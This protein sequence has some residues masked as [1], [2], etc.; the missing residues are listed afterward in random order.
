MKLNEMTTEQIMAELQKVFSQSQLKLAQEKL[1]NLIKT[2]ETIEQLV[3]R[4]YEAVNV[5]IEE[6]QV[7]V[8]KKINRLDTRKDNL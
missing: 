7:K 3:A 4:V 1:T 5:E 8:N 2:S 6:T